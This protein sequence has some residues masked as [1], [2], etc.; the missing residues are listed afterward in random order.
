MY[1]V[2]DVITFC[3]AEFRPHIENMGKRHVTDSDGK[4][5]NTEIWAYVEVRP[6]AHMFWWLYYTYHPDGHL[7]RP[8]VI[9]LQVTAS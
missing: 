6:G 3:S 9:W 4:Q 8:I 1:N 2:C 7:N 5:R